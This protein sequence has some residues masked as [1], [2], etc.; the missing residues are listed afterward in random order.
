[1]LSDGSRQIISFLL[2]G[3]L[4]STAL[5]FG[6]RPHCNIEA[7]TDVSYRK[8]RRGDLKAALL[9][10]PDLLEKVFKL[11]SEETDRADQLIIDLGRRTAEERVARLIFNLAER[12]NLRGMTRVTADS[13]LEMEFPLRQHQ[14][15][16]ATGLTAVHVNKV[17]STLRRDGLIH[18][19]DRSLTIPNLTAFRQFAQMR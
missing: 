11:W 2:G 10:F 4:P 9:Q 13:F 19:N 3:D 17:M 16:D 7:I 5:L 8:F 6:P 15:A 1:M 14:I 18:I 12:L